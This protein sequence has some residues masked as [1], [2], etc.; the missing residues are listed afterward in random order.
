MGSA[1]RVCDHVGYSPL[2]L[3]ETCISFSFL[4]SVKLSGARVD[5]V[6]DLVKLLALLKF[7]GL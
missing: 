5:V 1:G 3:G 7:E 2:V 6:Q 4:L